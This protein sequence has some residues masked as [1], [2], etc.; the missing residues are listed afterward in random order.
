MLNFIKKY[1]IKKFDL[2]DRKAAP[3]W[4]AFD[5]EKID[6]IIALINVRKETLKSVSLEAADRENLEIIIDDLALLA[7]ILSTN[8]VLKPA[9]V[10]ALGPEYFGPQ[11]CLDALEIAEI[12]EE[13]IK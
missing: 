10:K 5:T 7:K 11:D 3:Y 12:A 6:G 1:L 4:T 9:E 8:T 13:E 2:I